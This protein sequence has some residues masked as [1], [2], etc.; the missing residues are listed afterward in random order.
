ML[1]MAAIGSGAG[2]ANYYAGDN[3]YTDGQLTEA[4]LWAGQAAELLGLSGKVEANVFEAVLAGNL[5]NGEVIPAGTRGEHRPGLDMTFSA[6]KSVSLLAY[7]GGDDRLLSAHIDAVKASL[8]WAEKTFAEA[9]V[10]KGR[11]QEVVGTSNLLVALF[12]HDTSRLLDPQAHVH[13]VIANATKAPDGKWRALAEYALWQ[14][15]TNIASVYNA[16]FRQRVEALG[17]RTEPTGKHG[18]F[19][20][21]GVDRNVIMAFSQRRTEIEQ[22]ATKLEHNTPAAMTAVTLRT[23]GDKPVNVD[24]MTL[25][26]EW[27]DRAKGLGFNAPAMVAEAT[28]RAAREETPWRRLVEGVKGIAEQGRVLVERLGL[29]EAT[30]P[31]DPLVPEKPGRLSPD[32]FAAAHAVASAVRHLS[33]REAGFR[34]VDLVKAALDLGAPVGVATVDAR[35]ASLVSKGLL[36]T[37]T[38]DRMMTTADALAQEK[39][40]LAAVRDGKGQAAPLLA[41]DDIGEAVKAEAR[42]T[43]IRM[44]AGQSRAA[45]QILESRDRVVHIQGNAGT[46]KSAMLAPVARMVEAEGRTVIGLA[47][48][49]A[50]TNRLKADVKIPAMTVA[51]FV[52]EHGALLSDAASREQCDA[53]IASLKGA[54]IVV[55]EASML[56]TRDA[57]KLVAIANAAEVGRLA[58]VGDTKQLGAVEAGKP[59]ALGQDAATV[60]MDENLRAKSPEMLALHKAAQSHDVAQLVRLVEPS[61]VEAPGAAAGTAAKMWTDLPIAERDRTSIFVSGRQLRDDVNREV[62]KLRQQRGEL[63]EALNIKDTLVPIRLTREEQKH[64]QSYRVGQVVEL[65]RPLTSQGLP[66]GQM[67]VMAIRPSGEIIVQLPGGKGALFRPARLAGNRVED[68]VRVFAVQDL[69]LRVGDPIRWTANDH[70]RGLANAETARFEGFDRSGLLFR[71][72]KG[73]NVALAQDDPMLKRIDLAYAANAHAS[74]GATADIAIV[75]AQS[76]EGALINR[77][78]VGAL[79]TRTREQVTFVVDNL[80]SFERRTRENAGEKASALEIAGEKAPALETAGQSMKRRPPG[81]SDPPPEHRRIKIIWPEREPAPEQYKF[82]LPE[83]EREID[84]G[85]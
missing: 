32:Q 18:Q 51:R 49:N 33:E 56:S 1:S 53:L 11:G 63:G 44:T 3:Y 48:S 52:R 29:V 31:A 41:R 27:Q 7:I 62:Q 72:A 22:E 8:A 30:A 55:D 73:N 69:T 80:S 42:T 13:A 19:E 38:N 21:A 37:G 2:A 77:S 16:E 14:S 61:A 79:F 71:T 74:Q 50:I 65:S 46:G 39:A 40:Y 70:A 26:A 24:R 20:I 9:R 36:I 58:L 60:V 81:I 12:Q 82:P 59:F 47:V 78:L 75:V 64:P 4:S 6:P 68:A 67:K 84:F 17:Y 28:M 66:A 83:R 43:G 57:A 85:R 10:S 34:K 76:T 23:R 25:H 54:L 45:T 35:I 5:P 15:K